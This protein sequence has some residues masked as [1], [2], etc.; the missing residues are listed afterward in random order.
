MCHPGLYAGKSKPASL[1]GNEAGF[2]LLEKKL[3]SAVIFESEGPQHPDAA[4]A[5]I[6]AK[7][8]G[9]ALVVV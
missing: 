9:D 8:A 3:M 2:V 4:G 5:G 6:G 1:Q 7:A